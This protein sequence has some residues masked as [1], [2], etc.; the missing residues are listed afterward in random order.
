MGGVGAW[1]ESENRKFDRANGLGEFA[2]KEVAKDDDTD[3]EFDSQGEELPDEE[4][5]ARRAEKRRVLK[6]MREAADVEEE[7]YEGR[8]DE[9]KRG[10]VWMEEGE[11]DD[12]SFAVSRL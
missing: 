3:C 10:K 11:G 6:E 5:E 7:S 1:R 8:E 12:V 2:E 9:K 4:Q